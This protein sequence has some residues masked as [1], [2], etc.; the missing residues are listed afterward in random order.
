M[1]RR[2]VLQVLVI[3]DLDSKESHFPVLPLVFDE[4]IERRLVVDETGVPS[5]GRVLKLNS[6]HPGFGQ[7][8]Q[9]EK[10]AAGTIE[11]TLKFSEQVKTEQLAGE[12]IV[13]A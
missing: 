12:Q 8:S 4:N 11:I 9:G 7:T 2:R 3:L 1:F 13:L 10:C 6:G 5:P